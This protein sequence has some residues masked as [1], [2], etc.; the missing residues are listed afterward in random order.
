MARTKS[1]KGRIVQ[2]YILKYADLLE[3]GTL[4]KGAL[5]KMILEDYPDDFKDKYKVLKSFEPGLNVAIEVG[6]IK[7]LEKTPN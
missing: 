3:K 2:E 1:R 4:K 7:D 5:A 6:K